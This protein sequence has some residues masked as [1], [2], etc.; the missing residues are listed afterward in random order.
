MSAVQEC[1]AYVFKVTQ[2]LSDRS[3]TLVSVEG[4]GFMGGAERENQSIIGIAAN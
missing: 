3:E 1:S 2:A 4:R